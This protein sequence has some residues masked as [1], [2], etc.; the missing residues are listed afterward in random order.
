MMPSDGTLNLIAMAVATAVV[1]FLWFYLSWR[2]F[3]VLPLWLA[4]YWGIPILIG[5]IQRPN[6]RTDMDSVRGKAG[7]GEPRD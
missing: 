4:I 1:A 7:P 5:L 2:W 3:A 6:A